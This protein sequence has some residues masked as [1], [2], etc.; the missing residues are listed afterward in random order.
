[1]SGPILSSFK[2]SQSSA[3]STSLKDSMKKQASTIVL[4]DQRMATNICSYLPYAAEYPRILKTFHLALEPA[5]VAAL[6]LRKVQLQ[7]ES[8]TRLQTFDTSLSE[9][10]QL[11][12]QQLEKSLGI[13]VAGRGDI[14]APILE[15]ITLRLN[16]YRTKEIALQEERATIEASY[17]QKITEIDCLTRIAE[18]RQERQIRKVAEQHHTPFDL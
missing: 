15:R 2:G 9:T 13:K 3:S 8:I 16:E 7:N 11:I 6:A 12:N 18:V 17:R 4:M 1:M 14:I 5:R 10:Q